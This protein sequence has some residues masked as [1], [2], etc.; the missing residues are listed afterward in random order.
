MLL[1]A[2]KY[3][4]TMIIIITNQHTDFEDKHTSLYSAAMSVF[5]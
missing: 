3:M 2:L 4:T 5:K 1:V